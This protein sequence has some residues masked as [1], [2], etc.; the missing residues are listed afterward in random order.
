M[1]INFKQLGIVT[2][3]VAPIIALAVWF[4]GAVVWQNDYF[5]DRDL[6]LQ[7]YNSDR[8]E[9]D[10]KLTEI[11]MIFYEMELASGED[12]N[13]SQRSKYQRLQ[14]YLISLE[15]QKNEDFNIN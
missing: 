9:T 7:V 4:T 3:A 1:N 6:F 10:I 2:G 14:A 15:N 8:V 13:R 11:A 5:R 12:L